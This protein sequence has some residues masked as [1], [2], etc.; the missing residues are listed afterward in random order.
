MSGTEYFNRI[1]NKKC[2][3]ITKKSNY[4]PNIC[5]DT[6]QN[7]SNNAEEYRRIENAKNK[8]SV[9]SPIA[10]YP[11]YDVP[12]QSIRVIKVLNEDAGSWS[13]SNIFLLI[14]HRLYQLTETAIN[15]VAILIDADSPNAENDTIDIFD[16][17]VKT[18]NSNNRHIL[19]YN[20]LIFQ[21]HASGKMK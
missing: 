18:L 2:F 7:E 11:N 12:L 20:L 14:G 21:R 15:L 1:P 8:T 13:T 3:L 6:A 19:L 17:Q 16:I 10:L 5:F 4:F 9:L